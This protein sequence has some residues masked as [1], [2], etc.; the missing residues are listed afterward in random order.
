MDVLRIVT[1]EARFWRQFQFQDCYVAPNLPPSFSFLEEII[2]G[3][4]QNFVLEM[5]FL[6]MA[7]PRFELLMLILAVI[8]NVEW[9]HVDIFENEGGPR[10]LRFKVQI[11]YLS[12]NVGSSTELK[13]ALRM[14]FRRLKMV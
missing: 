10:S 4:G 12:S 5:L 9:E 8:T 14:R 6:P 3:S 11:G 1:I 2:L 7:E 13:V